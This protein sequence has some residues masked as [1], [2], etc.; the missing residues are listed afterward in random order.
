MGEPSEEK[1]NIYVLFLVKK[2]CFMDWTDHANNECHDPFEICSKYIYK[3][4]NEIHFVS[5]NTSGE[6]TILKQK[7]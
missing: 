6:I 4:N 7:V 1:S 3:I 5:K 2:I